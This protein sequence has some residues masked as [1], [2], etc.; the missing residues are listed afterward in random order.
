[1]TA[2]LVTP[3]NPA[4]IVNNGNQGAGIMAAFLGLNTVQQVRHFLAANGLPQKPWKGAT[5]VL[6]ALEG[7][8]A[9]RAEDPAFWVPLRALLGQLQA[10]A[11]SMDCPYLPCPEAEI[12]K[13]A[14]L[15]EVI[16]DL[17]AALPGRAEDRPHVALTRLAA[18]SLCCVLLLAMAAG[19]ESSGGGKEPGDVGVEAEAGTDAQVE[20]DAEPDVQ[21][22]A[23]AGPD[24]QVEADVEPDVQ[25]EA[26]AGP[27]AQVEADAGT[28]CYD[29]PLYWDWSNA[30]HA[31]IGADLT[32]YVE[33]SNLDPHTKDQ[34]LACLGF[35]SATERADMVTLFQTKS[36]EEIAQYLQAVAQSDTCNPTVEVCYPCDEGVP[37]YKGVSFPVGPK[38]RS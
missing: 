32:A 15:D 33:G 18:P 14:R 16:A 22:E 8:L 9:A 19:C 26:D 35:Y 12:L 7:L 6:G 27:D 5:E 3:L 38:R 11:R 37:A 29:R 20:A 31:D 10:H 34:L 2:G 4:T 17:K 1:M 25:V 21:V 30:P 23:D 36:P 24:A 13:A 28:C